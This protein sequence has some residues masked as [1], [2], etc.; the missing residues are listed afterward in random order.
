MSR[1]QGAR[2]IVKGNAVPVLDQEDEL[3]GSRQVVLILRLVLDRQARLHHGELVDIESVSQ[4]RFASLNGL[5]DVVTRWF[6][7]H[8]PADPT[9]ADPMM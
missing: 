7:R 9:D 6:E 1:C 8:C 2:Q 5:T 4:G 3:A